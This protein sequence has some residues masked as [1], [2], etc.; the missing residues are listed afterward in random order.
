MPA[1]H[2]DPWAVNVDLHC[3]SRFSDGVLAP[4]ALVRRAHAN[5]VAVLAL[6][7]H[8]ELD[9]LPEAAAVAREVAMA[10]VPGVEISVTW[11]Q[12]TIHLVGLRIDPRTPAL[13]DGLAGIRRGRDAR[14][15]AMGESLA[16]AGIADAYQGACAYA[17]NPDLVS[18]TH[19][20]RYLVDS[21][22]CATVQDVFQRFLVT[23]KPGYVPHRWASLRDAMD[24]IHAA[25]GV[26]V[27]AHPGRYRLDPTA[28]WALLHEF[29]EAGGVAI[30]VVT[31]SHTRDQYRRFAALAREF[32]L[33]ASRGSDFHCPEESRVDLGALPPLPDGVVPVWSDWTDAMPQN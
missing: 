18:R 8:D 6:T 5:G 11:A 16:R 19:F 17:T 30:E 14:A 20:A 21:G 31:G 1:D 15:R 10:F 33:Q 26:G 3:H 29:R 23:G 25:G 13:R 22:H 4:D 12:Q 2:R 32:G 7:D 9:G 28:L 27:L 24:W